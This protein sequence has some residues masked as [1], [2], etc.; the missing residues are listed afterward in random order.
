[1][2]CH[3]GSGCYAHLLLSRW[4]GSAA[5]EEEYTVVNHYVR[6]VRLSSSMASPLG[7]LTASPTRFHCRN[8]LQ[9][10]SIT[11]SLCWVAFRSLKAKGVLDGIN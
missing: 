5:Q 6:S 11:P 9:K 2:D 8:Y 10:V 4:P 1:M 7:G 3:P